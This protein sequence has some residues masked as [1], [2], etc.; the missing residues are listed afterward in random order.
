MPEKTYLLRFFKFLLIKLERAMEW[1]F[2]IIVNPTVI[3]QEEKVLTS[4]DFLF[5]SE[6][7]HGTLWLS[8]HS[9]HIM[10]ILSSA[11]KRVAQDRSTL[12]YS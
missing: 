1:S 4:S 3:K 10:R 8:P 2:Q 12:N 6:K 11:G 9:S 5:V 7:H